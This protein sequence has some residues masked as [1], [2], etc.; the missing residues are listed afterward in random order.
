M[1]RTVNWRRV[2]VR[3][4]RLVLATALALGLAGLTLRYGG[5][6]LPGPSDIEHRGS[7]P[8]A[9]AETKFGGGMDAAGRFRL[10]YSADGDCFY[11]EPE[12]ARPGSQSSRTPIIWPAGTNGFQK[13]ERVG[14]SI[15][16]GD[17]PW[18][19]FGRATLWVGDLVEAAGGEIDLP[20]SLSGLAP[21]CFG[22]DA[23]R[24]AWVVAEARTED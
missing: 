20:A 22:D 5:P 13:G 6:W 12:T 24:K 14:V 2:S 7:Q 23:A 3:R 15:L 16:T 17:M 11:A 9:F 8:R 1:A 19:L 10:G 21:V 4:R 18:D